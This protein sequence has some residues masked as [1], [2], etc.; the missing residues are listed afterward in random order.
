MALDHYIS[1]VHLKNFYSPALNGRLLHAISKNDLKY[2]TPDSKSVCR[3]D[4]GNTN[5]Y[6]KEPRIIEEFL[7]TI[8]GK[9]NSSV[10]RLR[11]GNIDSE[12]IYTI[13]GFVSYV[14]SCSPAAMRLSSVPLRGTVEMTVAMLD[15]QKKLPV[16]PP[17][18][19]EIT[20]T[21]AIKNGDVEI[22]VDQKFPQAIGIASI[23]ERTSTFG[24]FNWEI[25]INNHNDCPFFTSDF[26][27]APERTP[28]VGI[29][30][31]LIPLAPNL[32]IR[33][34]PNLLEIS[35]REAMEINKLLVRA[36]EETVFFRDNKRWVSSFVQKNKGYQVE[37]VT[38]QLEMN[39]GIMQI[40]RQMILPHTATTSKSI[41]NP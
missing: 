35:R 16:A 15:R 17:E 13:S 22:S 21:E 1:Q 12:C 6:L 30:N 40:S 41:A 24:N 37:T 26:P 28:D 9:Y 7:K 10:E 11:R 33:I 25:L 8:E 14:A 3:L 32:A 27:V 23:L 34:C 20:L 5:E 36:A 18:L 39:E 4:E 38:S 2:F 31:R 29:V 19:G